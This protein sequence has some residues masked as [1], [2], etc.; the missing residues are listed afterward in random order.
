VP[1]LEATEIAPGA[2]DAKGDNAM[3]NLDL[4]FLLLIPLG[5]AEAF[6]F[7]ALWHLLLESWPRRRVRAGESRR[8]PGFQLESR[9]QLI[10]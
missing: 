10:R 5:L 9:I 8:E 6:L 2:A 4:R 7:W 1:T 3:I